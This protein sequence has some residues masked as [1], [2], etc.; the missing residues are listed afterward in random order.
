MLS[1]ESGEFGEWEDLSVSLEDGMV[2]WPG[3]P[4]FSIGRIIDMEKGGSLNL[5]RIELTVHA[6]TH[7]DSPLHYL[8]TGKS[9][10]EAPLSALIGRARIVEIRDPESIKTAELRSIGLQKGQRILFKTA[11]STKHLKNMKQMKNISYINPGAFAEDFIHL[12]VEAATYLVQCGV[13]TVG[14][15]YLSVGGYKDDGDEVHRILLGG[16]VWIIEGLDLSMVTPG[17]Y[18]FI[19]LPL[20]ITGAEGAPARAVARKLISGGSHKAVI[21]TI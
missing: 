2:M 14:I 5:S 21:A 12:T 6:G 19:C 11:N 20:K 13:Q 15:D 7:V 9:I 3:D 10:D 16:G 8:Q 18:E 17:D 1:E 4:P